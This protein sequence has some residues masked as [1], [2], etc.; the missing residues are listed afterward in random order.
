MISE[1]GC[2]GPFS[3]GQFSNAKLSNYGKSEVLSQTFM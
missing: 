1:S 2:T 3:T